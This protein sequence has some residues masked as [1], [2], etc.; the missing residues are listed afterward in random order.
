MNVQSSIRVGVIGTGFGALTHIPGFQRSQDVEVVAVASGR[1]QRARQVAAKFGLQASYGDYRQML[2]EQQLDLVSIVT[3]PGLHHEMALAV[4]ES[5]CAVLCEKPFAMSLTEAREMLA[6]AEAAGVVHAVNHE[7]RYLPARARMK[8]LV[9]QGYLGQLWTVRVDALSD[10]LIDV[11]TRPW[12]WWSDRSQGGGILGAFGSHLLDSLSW[13]FGPIV[14]VSAQ[15]DTFVK[16]RPVRGTSEW[17][18]VTADD[19]AVAL[20]RLANGAQA[21]YFLSGVSRAG[22]SRFE[23][24]GSEGSL[25]I[26]GA[27]LLGARGKAALEPIDLPPAPALQPG[28]DFR[29]SPFLSFLERFLPTVRGVAGK[30]VASFHDGVYIQ[31]VMDAMH[32]SS[33]EKRSV[34]VAAP[35]PR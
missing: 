26:D 11:A 22:Q 25:V 33:D 23:A 4:V 29:I 35:A 28:D 9:D 6:A 7:F 5:G 16:K 27:N 2:A 10:V 31:A 18:E 34:A 30:P 13:W 19:Q 21:T 14:E 12:T 1:E 8:E 24:H 15:L 17:R 20:F 32:Q 3:P